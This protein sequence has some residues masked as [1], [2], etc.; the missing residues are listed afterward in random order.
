MITV[1]RPQM[2]VEIKGEKMFTIF[3]AD[4]FDINGQFFIL[5]LDG[6]NVGAFKISKVERIV[7]H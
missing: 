7:R 5:K 4:S 6:K 3:E 2:V 1:A